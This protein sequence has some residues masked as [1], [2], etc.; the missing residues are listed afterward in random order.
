MCELKILIIVKGGYKSE[1]QEYAAIPSIFISVALL[2][3]CSSMGIG[4][5]GRSS[6]E[7]SNK[8]TYI[9]YSDWMEYDSIESLFIESDYVIRGKVIDTR[10]EWLSHCI[11]LNP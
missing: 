11:P 8:E 3:A 6:T 7:S 1:A 2:S 5:P 10:A 4:D 9:S